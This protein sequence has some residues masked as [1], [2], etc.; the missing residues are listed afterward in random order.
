MAGGTSSPL[1]PVGVALARAEALAAHLGRRTRL[2]GWLACAAAPAVWAIALHRW[3]FGSW[4][5]ALAWLPVLL[6]L[7]IPGLVLLGFGTRV[8]RIA[9]LPAWVSAEVGALVADGRDGAAA[10]IEGGKVSGIGGLRNLVGALGDLR[11]H[12]GDA[13]RII[14]GVAGT[15]R[16]TNRIYLMVVLGSAVA[17]GLLAILLVVALVLLFVI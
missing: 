9:D 17:A 6:A 3:V 12:G 14:S 15:V 10:E 11:S 7:L 13:R 1:P 16:V 5:V 8:R 2:W 4:R